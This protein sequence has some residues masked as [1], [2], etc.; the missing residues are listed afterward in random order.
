MGSIL[1]EWLK[2]KVNRQISGN[3]KGR[4]LNLDLCI[5]LLDRTK[6]PECDINDRVKDKKYIL[7][8]TSARKGKQHLTNPVY[9]VRFGRL[10]DRRTK[11]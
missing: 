7:F 5:E 2:K 8:S 11:G 4:N 3:K 9:P 1:L 10:K 6:A